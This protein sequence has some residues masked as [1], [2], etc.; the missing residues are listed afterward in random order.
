[1]NRPPPVQTWPDAVLFQGPALHDL[2]FL[3]ANGIRATVYTARHRTRHFEGIQRAIEDALSPTR[4][5][6]VALV[7][8]TA[9][10]EGQLIDEV[11]TV[12]TK[13]AA[14]MAGVSQRTVQ[15]WCEDGGLGWR[16]EGRWRVERVRLVAKLADRKGT[17]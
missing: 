9:A 2:Q 4:Q 3:V 5:G 12:S 10:A 1:M 6:D 17:K 16:E 11:D 7:A 14:A 13:T 15:R 8:E